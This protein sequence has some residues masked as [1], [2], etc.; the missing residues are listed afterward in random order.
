MWN[1]SSSKSGL[2][3]FGRSWSQAAKRC[4]MRQP[5]KSLEHVFVFK[6]TTVHSRLATMIKEGQAN[7]NVI[8]ISIATGF[9]IQ[10]TLKSVYKSNIQNVQNVHEGI[11]CH[12]N[13]T[14]R[15]RII[16]PPRAQTI[17][18]FAGFERIF[19]LQ[20]TRGE[21]VWILEV[22]K[23][24]VPPTGTLTGRLE[25]QSFGKVSN[26]SNTTRSDHMEFW[27]NWKER[28]SPIT[29][30][31]FVLVLF[32]FS[33]CLNVFCLSAMGTGTSSIKPWRHCL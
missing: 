23:N 4:W 7:E 15:N 9:H 11:K 3:F 25:C 10:D 13:S 21:N 31:S 2:Y 6:L 1:G 18:N 19:S 26:P 28:I 14:E 5:R 32:F 8:R 33:N 17:W 24:Q 12:P 22:Q 30:N 16:Q 20:T 27:I 29:L